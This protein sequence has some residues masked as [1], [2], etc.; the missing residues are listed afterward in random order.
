MFS[1]DTP[2]KCSIQV[3][4]LAYAHNTQPLSHLEFSIHEIVFH[5]QPRIPL[6]FHF[7]LFEIGFVKVLH[8]NTLKLLFTLIINQ[9]IPI[10]FFVALC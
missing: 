1:H 10:R 4:F 9:L 3:H 5:T 2:E 6:N 8:I 7:K